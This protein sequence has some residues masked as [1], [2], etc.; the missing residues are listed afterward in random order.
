MLLHNE[1]L[2]RIYFGNADD[3]LFPHTYFNL[4]FDL[5][6]LT[7]EPFAKL[8]KI[9]DIQS[10]LFL[11]QIHNAAGYVISK[12]NRAEFVPFKSEG[13]FLITRVSHV[14][15]GVMSA[16]CLP[17]VC[18]DKRNNVVGIAHAGW[19]GSAQ[20]V[21]VAMIERMQQEFDT[22]FG[23]LKI[24]FGPSAK[25]C[26]YQITPDFIGQFESYPFVQQAVQEH[27]QALFFDLPGFNRLQLEAMGVKKKSFHLDYNICTICDEKFFSYR[28]QKDRSGR[29]MTVVCLK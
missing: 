3:Q 23:E 15:L 12:E 13:D 5:D 28:R 21:G 29:Q 9:M 18:Y 17:I 8:K 24:F 22:E 2:F 10:L 20:G 11:K 19:K 4:F 1:P 16:D 25:V 7:I 14:G 26:C 27:G 6:I